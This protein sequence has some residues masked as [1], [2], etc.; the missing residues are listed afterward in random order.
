MNDYVLITK[1]TIYGT[2]S[3]VN[4]RIAIK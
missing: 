1:V 4:E 3:K 2:S